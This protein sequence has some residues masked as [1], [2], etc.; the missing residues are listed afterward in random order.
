MIIKQS[1]PLIELA[2]FDYIRRIIKSSQVAKGV[3]VDQ[4]QSKMNRIIGLRHSFA[5]SNGTAA[6]HLALLSLGIKKSDDVIIPSYTCT[7]L[8]NVIYYVGAN[9]VLV[10]IDAETFNLTPNT[11]KHKLTKKTKAIIVTHTF[12]FPGDLDG[13]L[14]LGIP[15]IEDCAH[16]IGSLY[17][18]KPTGTKGRIAIFSMYATKM[19]SSGEGGM[20]CTNDNTIAKRIC[21]LNNPDKREDYKVRYNYKMSDLTAG[22]ALNQL[23]KLKR[24][25]DCRISIATKYKKAFA[26]LPV[27]FQK[28]L[29]MT[30]PNY[31]RFIDFTSKAN[32]IIKFMQHH[33]IMC[34]K[35]VHKPLHHYIGSTGSFTG[36]DAVWNMAVSVPI[37]PALKDKQILRIINTT[38]SYFNNYSK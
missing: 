7:A 30:R 10:D 8:L 23:K 31:Y 6:L 13:I 15:I 24:F 38:K 26:T 33:G 14:K 21:D 1:M 12:G 27:N 28:Q 37:Y 20:I 32:K 18:G 35:P 22:L 11:I 4:L 16:S 17:K 34:D 29:P 3:F 5:T 19:L 36:T 9:P 2:D 25:V